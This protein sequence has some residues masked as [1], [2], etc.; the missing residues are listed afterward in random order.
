MTTSS[1]AFFLLI[2]FFLANCAI[3]KGYKLKAKLLSLFE[4]SLEPPKKVR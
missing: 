2:T 1:I 4:I 3:S